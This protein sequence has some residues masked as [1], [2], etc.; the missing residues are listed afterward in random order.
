MNKATK[1]PEKKKQIVKQLSQLVKDYPIV[2][3]VNMENLP[4]KQLQTMKDQLRDTVEII[5]TKQRMIKIILE[6]CDAD[7]KDIKN[8]IDYFRGMPAMIFTKENPFTLYKNLNKNKSSAPAKGGQTATKD[9]IIPAGP[10][11]FSPGPIIGELATFRI[12]S[13]VEDG[14]VAI[15]EDS[16]VVKEGEVISADLAGIL[17]RLGIEPMEIG[18]DLVAVYED[19]SIFTKNVLAIDEDEY[20]NNVATAASDSFRLALS[21]AYTTEDTIKPL[22]QNAFNDAKAIGLS[23]GILADELVKEIISKA[24][25]EMNGLKSKLNIEIPEKK[26]DEAKVEEKVEEKPVQEAK[27]EEKVEEKPVQE[28]KV[29]EKVEEKP[30]QEAKVE[31]KVE[32]KPVQEAKVEEKVEEK[33]AEADKAEEKKE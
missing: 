22:I 17:T 12:K 9:I 14:K 27:V 6:N 26:V 10:T 11:P 15:K 30:V 32:E 2:G 29:E 33:P 4:A 28:A 13:G 5:M 16:L 25:N 3:I 8:L 21:L 19:G 24:E 23:E 7:K 1:I 31:E 20:M 18:L